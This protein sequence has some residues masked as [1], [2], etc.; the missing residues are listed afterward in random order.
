MDNPTKSLLCTNSER[1]R[2]DSPE[3]KLA[4]YHQLHKIPVEPPCDVCPW[5][6]YP[7]RVQG[8]GNAGCGW[9]LLYLAMDYYQRKNGY[10]PFKGDEVR[11][12]KVLIN[13]AIKLLERVS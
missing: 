10:W 1:H 6:K 12:A 5:R 4:I 2:P 11:M 8:C 9:M 13:D 3:E 7:E